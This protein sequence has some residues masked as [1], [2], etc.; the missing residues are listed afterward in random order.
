MSRLADADRATLP[1]GVVLLAP[2]F[3]SVFVVPENPDGLLARVLSLVPVTAPMVMPARTAMGEPAL[4]EITLSVALMIPAIV[5]MVWL[6]G[7]IY[8]GA[9]LGMGPRVG[10]LQALRSS[11]ETR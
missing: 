4:W 2:Y 3:L 11:G 8:A 1:L 6:A 7:R 5:G 10:L 9:I